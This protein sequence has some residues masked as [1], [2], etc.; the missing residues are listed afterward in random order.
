MTQIH[1]DPDT[2][3][4][5]IDVRPDWKAHYS[6]KSLYTLLECLHGRQQK[7]ES[8]LGPFRQWLLQNYP[9][10]GE[11]K[12]ERED[13]LNE[14]LSITKEKEEKWKAASLNDMRM[15]GYI[16]QLDS[17]PGLCIHVVRFACWDM[18]EPQCVMGE[19]EPVDREMYCFA[20]HDFWNVEMM[21]R[22]IVWYH[23]MMLKLLN[24]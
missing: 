15:S 17:D 21:D 24:D 13:E 3:S 5:T 8:I 4:I 7:G 22:F 12:K 9:L 10:D 2:M 11:T 1:V 6:A 16:L 20:Q 18:E 14:L 23:Q 19:G